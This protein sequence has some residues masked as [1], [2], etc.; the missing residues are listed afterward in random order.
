MGRH[1]DD[2]PPVPGRDRQARPR[3]PPEGDRASAASRSGSRSRPATRS[4][5]RPT[6]VEALSRTVGGVVREL[7]SWKW[8]KND[9]RGL[10][11]LDYTQ[12]Q[13][14]KTLVA[15]Y[16]IRPA[17]GRAGVGAAGVGRA[18]RSRAAPRPLDDPRRARRA[19]R[20]RRPVRRAR[21]PGTGAAS[22]C[23]RQPISGSPTEHEYSCDHASSSVDGF[24][25][26]RHGRHPDQ[27][28]SRR[29]QEEHLVQPA[30]RP[31][32]VAHPLPQGQR[33]DRRGGAVRAHRQGL[34][35]R[36][37]Q[38]R[39]PHRRRPG[40][41]AAG[42]VQGD[43]PRDVRARG[44][45]QPDDVRLVLPRPAR[46]ERQAVRPAGRRH[47]RVGTCRHR[48]LRDA[49][50]GVPGGDPLRR[51]ASHAVARSCSP[52]S[53]SSRRRSTSSRN[54]TRSRSPTRS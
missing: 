41:A 19:W 20:R 18:R 24:D 52:T 35:P 4:R 22:C 40:P 11:R 34:R 28:R 16:S 47:G 51:H 38:L 33:G 3:R 48:S 54:W 37:R 5:R 14:N 21:R 43:R 30:R 50:E 27:A 44:R 9:R 15:P 49:P 12:N 29:S 7:V 25:L 23:S 8:H 10:A 45:G 32:D 13:I 39:R 2:R 36:R 6:F 42:E 1:A 26:V 31:H 53:W 46:Q 17:A